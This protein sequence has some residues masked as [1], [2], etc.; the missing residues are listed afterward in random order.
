MFTVAKIRDMFL[1]FFEKKG[2]TLVPGSSLVP[3]NDDTLLFTNAGM[4]QFKNVFLGLE[5]RKYV[6]AASSQPCVR[7]G[8][9]HNDLENVGYTARHHT[10]FEMLGNFSFG[11]YFKKEA[12]VLAWEFLTQELKLP[13]EKLWVSVYFDDHEAEAIWLNDIKIDPNRISRCG[14]KDNFWS[15]GDTGPCGPC[16]EIFYDH[17]AHLW[18]GPPGSPEQDGD[19]Y[20]EIWNLVFMQFN[21]ASDGTLSVLPKQSVD[22]GMGLERLAAVMQGVHSNYQIDLFQGLI[23]AAA[24]VLQ[25]TDLNNPSLQVLADHIRSCSFLIMDGVLPSNEG[26]GYV[27]RRIIRRAIRHGK[28]LA[29]HLP[30]PFFYKLVE[31]LVVQMGQAYSELHNK[32]AHIEKIL[33]KE[34]RQFSKTLEQGLNILEQAIQAILETNIDAHTPTERKI[35]PG[36]LVFKLYDTYGFPMDLTRD[37]ARERDLLVD[38]QGF[39]QHMDEQRERARKSSQ[40]TVDYNTKIEDLGVSAFSGYEHLED[41]GCIV[42]IIKDGQKVDSLDAGEQGIIILDKTPFYAESGGQ[43]GDEGIL[44]LAQKEGLF[45]VQD[46]KKSEQAALHYGFLQTGHLQVNDQVIAKV[47]EKARAATRLNHSATHLLHAALRTIVGTHV[48]QKGSLVSAER[49]RFDFA[50][51]EPLTEN[52]IS[53]IEQLVNEQIRANT[54]IETNIMEVEQA[55]EQGAMALFGEKYSEKVRVLKMGNGF[56][57]ELCGGTHAQRTGDIGLMVIIG[58]TGIASGV[59]RIEALT[60]ARAFEYVKDSD[61]QLKKVSELLKTDKVNIET[62]LNSLLVNLKNIER[63]NQAYKLKLAIEQAHAALASEVVVMDDIK[64]LVKRLANDSDPKMLR[65]LIES[66]KNSLGKAVIVL[67]LTENQKVHL[68]VGVSEHCTNRIKA[69]ELIH[70]LAPQVGAKGGGRADIAQAGGNQPENLDSALN[71]VLGW[72]EK[73]IGLK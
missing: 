59:R 13:K 64:V 21:R 44:H 53:A 18:G 17:G 25:C 45:V 16:T 70:F 34:E 51:Y 5:S 3:Q 31:S 39:A 48:V 55:L 50:H 47:D 30:E 58:E 23:K 10:F 6:K 56:S 33:E 38:E 32:Q 54:V 15:M 35:I 7:A 1:D 40:F 14:E 12:I 29:P 63:E 24:Q 36:E 65:E 71:S 41:R 37:I 42:S 60:G 72:I 57:V 43:V 8:G 62:K 67:G 73:S 66:L 69:G 46:T 49:L 52:Q 9:K 26:R 68:I 61:T 2:H 19:R 20:I 27:L 22:T 4:V 11:D 28:K